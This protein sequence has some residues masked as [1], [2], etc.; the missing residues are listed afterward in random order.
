MPADG[1]SSPMDS[2]DP[3]PYVG[4]RQPSL[5]RLGG[6]LARRR[7][8]RAGRSR[9]AAGPSALR[10][11]DGDGTPSRPDTPGRPDGGRLRLRD[12]RPADR[13]PGE[14]GRHGKPVPMDRVICGVWAM[15][16]PRSP[17]GRRSKAV[18]DGKQ[19][20]VL[21]PTTLLADQ[22]LQTFAE[23][24]A[25]FPSR[26][27]T[28]PVHRRRRVPTSVGGDGRRQRRHRH[29]HP[30][31]AADRRPLEGPR[32]GDRRRGAALRRRTQ[33][34]HQ[35]PAQP[36][37]RADHERHPDPAHPGDE[38]GGHPRDVDHPHSRPGRYP[39]LTY[40][41][42]ARRQAGRRRPAP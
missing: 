19:V 29:R 12:R 38:P 24:M 40:V 9:I 2:L 15:A 16:R 23:R 1:S 14:S 4:G 42:P 10:Q 37:R 6:R 26:S 7:P 25:G 13:H 5:S 36:R 21:V 18:Q 3:V 27:G 20:A 11:T 17:C 41:G 28:V 34:T 39:V 22:H 30:P 33:G 31:A 32:P 35:G 8:R